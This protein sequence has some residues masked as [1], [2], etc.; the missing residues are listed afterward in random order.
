MILRYININYFFLGVVF[1]LLAGV[2]GCGDVGAGIDEG[3]FL[4]ELLLDIRI[5]SDDDDEFTVCGIETMNTN[6]FLIVFVALLLTIDEVLL[7]YQ[8]LCQLLP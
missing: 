7:S 4:D 3:A 6:N 8:I 5:T 2:D 1:A